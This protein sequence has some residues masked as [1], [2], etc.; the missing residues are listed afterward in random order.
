MRPTAVR[1]F[2]HRP[3]RFPRRVRLPAARALKGSGFPEVATLLAGA[4]FAL[5]GGE[6]PVFRA[7]LFS[8]VLTLAVGQDAGLLCTAWC[9]DTTPAGC[10]H[11]D[12]TSPSVSAHDNC[13]TDVGAAVAFVREDARRTSAAPDAQNALIVPRFRLAPSP[14]DVRPGFESGQ[15]GPLEERPLAIAL[16]I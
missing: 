16:R 15:R 2:R 9:P 3:A 1:D 10:P 8:I 5:L 11:Q 12:S 4:A 13:S 6:Y 14:T 7:A